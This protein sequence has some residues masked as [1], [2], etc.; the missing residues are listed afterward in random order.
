MSQHEPPGGIGRGGSDAADRDTEEIRVEIE[1]T[2]AVMPETRLTLR[3]VSGSISSSLIRRQTDR[4][5]P[6]AP[7]TATLSSMRS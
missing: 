3:G 6:S 7:H 4:N 2:P 1:Q 5:A